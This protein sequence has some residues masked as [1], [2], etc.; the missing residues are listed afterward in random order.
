MR[1]AWWVDAPWLYRDLCCKRRQLRGLMLWFS[2]IGFWAGRRSSILGVWAAPAAQQTIPKGGGRSPPPSGM[3]FRAAGAAK[4]SKI[5]DCRPAPKPCIKHFNVFGLPSSWD[6]SRSPPPSGRVEGAAGGSRDVVLS[7]EAG[8]P[9]PVNKNN[10]PELS[11]VL[12][13]F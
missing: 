11:P 7:Q 9:K 1:F 3:G 5:I 8:R 13:R 2:I 4:T 6:R 12:I 10:A